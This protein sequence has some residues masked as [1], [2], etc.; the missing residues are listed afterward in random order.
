MGAILI[1]VAAPLVLVFR[2]HLA[3]LFLTPAALLIHA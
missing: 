1:V 3:F 2:H